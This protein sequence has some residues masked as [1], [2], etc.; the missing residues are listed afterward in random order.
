MATLAYQQQP[1]D[2]Q[3]KIV[4]V[5]Q[6]ATA[7]NSTGLAASKIFT[8][9]FSYLKK[10]YRTKVMKVLYA[11]REAMYKVVMPGAINGGTI[12]HWLQRKNNNWAVLLG[13]ELDSKLLKAVTSAI[14]YVD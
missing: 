6:E 3:L 4:T 13:E 2:V 14:D 5:T 9:S 12:V 10:A 7:K 8:I 11:D 1:V